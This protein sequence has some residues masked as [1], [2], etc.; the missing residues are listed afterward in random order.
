M[1]RTSSLGQGYDFA[2][3]GKIAGNA[4]AKM[5]RQNRPKI[6]SLKPSAELQKEFSLHLQLLKRLKASARFRVGNIEI[7]ASQLQKA[8]AVVAEFVKTGNIGLLDQFEFYQIEGEDGRGNVHF[9]GYYTPLLPAREKP[10]KVFCHP[11]YAMPRFKPLPT[12]KEIDHEQALARKGLEL[13]YTSSLLD[14]FFLSVQG[15]G[16]LEFEDGSR[17]K[18]GY[19]GSNGHPYKSVG[20]MLVNSG[21]IPAEKISLRSIRAWFDK[22]PD[23]LAEVLNQNPSYSFYAWRQKVITGAAGISLIPM[24]SV[25]V[26]QS[27]IP[28]GA[29]LLAEVPQLDAEGR[30]VGHAFQLLFAHD[31]GGAIRGPG[32]LDLYH[33]VGVEAGNRAGDLHHYGRVWLLLPR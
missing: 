8:G 25:A 21:A 4:F 20:K 28:Y 15:S 30:L 27:C 29:C 23:K 26:D 2:G 7:T 9:T 17:K 5:Y 18:V 16:I 12:R 22:H 14:N 24:H 10:D 13:A 31:C 6:D 33:G 3:N 32:H 11:I 19:I 1:A